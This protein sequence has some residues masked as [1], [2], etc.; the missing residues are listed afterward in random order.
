MFSN[1]CIEQAFFFTLCKP[2]LHFKNMAS[3]K[4]MHFSDEN[5]LYS[6]IVE[7]KCIRICNGGLFHL[8]NKISKSTQ[9]QLEMASWSW[10][11]FPRK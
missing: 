10:K 9:S 11:M 5:K 4:C 8:Q 1:K 7:Y 3:L 2:I 6:Q